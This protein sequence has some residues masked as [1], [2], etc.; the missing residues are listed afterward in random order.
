MPKQNVG[1]EV[2]AKRCQFSKETVRQVF[3]TL[4]TMLEEG[5]SI[6]IQNFGKFEPSYQTPRTVR[7]PALPGGEAQAVRRRRVRFILSPSLRKRWIMGE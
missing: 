6:T 1:L 4:V 3:D 2:F 7:S 5:H